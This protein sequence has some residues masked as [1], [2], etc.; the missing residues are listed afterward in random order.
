M[1]ADISR[2]SPV[3][4]STCMGQQLSERVIIDPLNSASVTHRPTFVMSL[5]VLA[6]A[7]TKRMPAEVEPAKKEWVVPRGIAAKSFCLVVAIT[8]AFLIL[9]SRGL[10]VTCRAAVSCDVEISRR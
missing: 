1:R 2:G 8:V 5:V 4:K 7:A 10:R 6:L 9:S 3:F